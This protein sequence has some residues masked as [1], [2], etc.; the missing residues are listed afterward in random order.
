VR[1]RE[2][3]EVKKTA[4]VFMVDG[5]TRE[6][7]HRFTLVEFAFA[8][9]GPLTIPQFTAACRAARYPGPADGMY[10]GSERGRVLTK[11]EDGTLELN[12]AFSRTW[13]THTCEKYRI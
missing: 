4:S 11:R 10:D 9:K 1:Q 6:E 5:G 3:T 7:P 8:V 2:V 12:M 13:E